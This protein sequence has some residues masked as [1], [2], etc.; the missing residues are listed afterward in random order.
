MGRRPGLHSWQGRGFFPLSQIS[1]QW[2]DPPVYQSV[3][4]KAME[5]WRWTLAVRSLDLAEIHLHGVV[6][7]TGVTLHITHISSAYP[8]D[9][10]QTYSVFYHYKPVVICKLHTHTHTGVSARTKTEDHCVTFYGS[11]AL[12]LWEQSFTVGRLPVRS[13]CKYFLYF[14]AKECFVTR[15]TIITSFVY[16]IYN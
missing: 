9:C 16:G 14:N 10:D 5:G 7:R 3:G 8:V 11:T 6:L 2:G 13:L 4:T 1:Y 15:I 12:C